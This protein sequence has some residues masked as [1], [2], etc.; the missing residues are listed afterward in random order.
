MPLAPWIAFEKLSSLVS[1]NNH[2]FVAALLC[3]VSECVNYMSHQLV[4]GG[5]DLLQ[6]CGV[7]LRIQFFCSGICVAED[8]SCDFILDDS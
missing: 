1:D 8:F 4:E 2:K 5:M 6:P 3:Y 7:R